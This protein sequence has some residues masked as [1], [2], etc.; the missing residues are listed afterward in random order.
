MQHSTYR[1]GFKQN[2]LQKFRCEL[3]NI[4]YIYIEYQLNRSE[5]MLLS[6][7]SDFSNSPKDMLNV[8]FFLNQFLFTECLSNDTKKLYNENVQP[9]KS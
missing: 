2:F 7:E 4:V 5:K 1:D 8:W 6:L 9:L 3:M